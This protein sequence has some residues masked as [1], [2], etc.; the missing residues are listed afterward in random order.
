MDRFLCKTGVL[1][2]G[3]SFC[4]CQLLLFELV[5]SYRALAWLSATRRDKKTLR[6]ALQHHESYC[7]V[8]VSIP[9]WL[10]TGQKLTCGFIKWTSV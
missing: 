3:T 2:R 4:T 9:T 5:D 7:R 1:L 10:P 6:V 8:L